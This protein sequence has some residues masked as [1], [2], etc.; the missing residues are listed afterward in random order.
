M[1]RPTLILGTATFGFDLTDFQSKE[2][3][4]DL[5]DTIK[6]IGITHLDTAVR[7]P[8][9]NPGR[10]EQLIGEAAEVSHA[11]TIDTKVHTTL[12]DTSGNLSRVAV[13]KSV[14]DSLKRLGLSQVRVLYAHAADKATPLEEQAL[15]FDAQVRMGHCKA[16]GVSNFPVPMLRS[17]LEICETKGYRKPQ[18][19]QGDYNIVTRGMESS[20]LPLLR[21]HNMHFVA[22]RSAAAGF[23]TGNLVSGNVTGT[24]MAPEHPYGKMIAQ[25]V[26]GD[27]GLREAMKQFMSKCEKLDINTLEVALRWMYWHSALGEGD[28]M[29]LGASKKKQI[30]ENVETLK[31]GPLEKGIL[32]VVD[33]LWAELKGSRGKV[34]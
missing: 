10:S 17:F 29:I 25:G 2:D 32:E 6:D 8:P 5:L 21:S 7:Y 22:F 24:R 4:L 31:K 15:A 28:G 13:E 27:E 12:P 20:L 16:Y 19:Y 30:L 14:A 3:V 18:Y 11:F 34:I 33:E 23:L 26:F 1:A 9:P